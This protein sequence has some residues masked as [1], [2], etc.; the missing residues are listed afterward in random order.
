[1]VQAP[2]EWWSI[3]TVHLRPS[4]ILVSQWPYT[5]DACDVG[6]LPNQ[7]Y[8]GTSRPLLA[9]TKGDVNNNDQLV[10]IYSLQL[11]SCTLIR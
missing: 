11:G 9:T 5:Y 3:R 6:T 8:P 1:M 10:I 7:T 4:L 2:T